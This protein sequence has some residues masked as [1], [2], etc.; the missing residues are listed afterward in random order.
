MN[1]EVCR[2]CGEVFEPQEVENGVCW[3]CMEH[4][5]KHRIDWDELYDKVD[6]PEREE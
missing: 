3:K 5:E 2:H 4:E 1:V 6:N